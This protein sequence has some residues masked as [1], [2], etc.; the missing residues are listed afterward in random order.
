MK[1][2]F[3]TIYKHVTDTLNRDLPEHLTYHNID[4]TL[5]V[6]K[7]AIFIAER[8]GVSKENIELLK[9][10]AIYHDIGF[11]KSHINHEAIGC[12]IVRKELKAYNYSEESIAIICGMIMA[13][14]IPQHPKTLLEKILADADLE[15]LG[16]KHFNFFSEKLY[17]ELKHY[18]ASFTRD[19][20]NAI[21]VRF[22]GNHSYHT[23]FCKHYKTHRMIKN[24]QQF[25]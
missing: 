22:V 13:T 23:A 14:K 16:T 3:E 21:Q 9:I 2:S 15:Y 6:L 5:Y 12:K 4:H 1:A 11:I 20:W 10:A 18:N 7:R 25:L 24:I 8:S 17:Q 19:E